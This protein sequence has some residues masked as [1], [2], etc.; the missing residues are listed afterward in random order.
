MVRLNVKKG[1]DSQFLFDTTVQI[2]VDELTTQL[3]VIYNGRLKVERIAAGVYYNDEHSWFVLRRMMLINSVY[4]V[5]IQRRYIYVSFK[6]SWI[7]YT[8]ENV[9]VVH[10]ST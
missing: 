6:I 4:F 10:N 3:M 5:Y 2:P 8:K 1:D 7:P 9:F